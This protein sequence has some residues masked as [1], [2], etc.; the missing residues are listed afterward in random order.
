MR[1]SYFRGSSA[2][3]PVPEGDDRKGLREVLDS[4]CCF[5]WPGHFES[6]LSR[7]FRLVNFPSVELGVLD[8]LVV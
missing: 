6:F 8:D 3:A 1:Q 2:S 7:E 4:Y 5:D